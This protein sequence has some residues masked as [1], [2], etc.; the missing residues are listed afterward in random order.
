MP[1]ALQ[2]LAVLLSLGKLGY[3]GPEVRS[4]DFILE[5]WVAV[6]RFFQPTPSWFQ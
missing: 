1:N 4:L 2:G 6:G 5:G 3:A